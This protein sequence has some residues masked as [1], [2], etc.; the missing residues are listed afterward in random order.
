MDTPDNTPTPL[1]VQQLRYAL[2]MNQL[3]FGEWLH[4]SRRAVQ[5]WEAGLRAMHPSTWELALLKAGRKPLVITHP[6]NANADL[7]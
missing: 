6:V 2:G 7:L 1:A 4:S 5:Q 3:E